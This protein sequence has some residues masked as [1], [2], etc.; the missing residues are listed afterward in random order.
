MQPTRIFIGIATLVMLACASAFTQNHFELIDSLQGDFSRTV[1]IMENAYHSGELSQRQYKHFMRWKIANEPYIGSNGRVNKNGRDIYREFQKY[2]RTHKTGLDQQRQANGHWSLV[3]P[4]DFSSTSPYNGRVNCIAVHPTNSN[5]IYVGTPVGGIWRSV[6]GGTSWSCLTDGVPFNS[7][8]S[9]QLHPDDPNHI[10]ALT[11]DGESED[12]L[13]MGLIESLDGGLSWQMT[14]LQWGPEDFQVGYDLLIDP[15]HPETMY[16]GTN[17]GLY[18]TNN[19]WTDTTRLHTGSIYDIALK[20]GDPGTLYAAS[21]KHLFRFDSSGGEFIKSSLSDGEGPSS[22]LPNPETVTSQRT[23]LAVSP[24]EPDWIYMLYARNTEG[25]GFIGLYHSEDGGETFVLRSLTPNIVGAGDNNQVTYDLELTAD[26][27]NAKTVYVGGIRLWRSLTKGSSGSWVCLANNTGLPNIHA[28]I[29][30][31]TFDGSTLFIGT[32]GGIV[33]STN[34]GSTYTNISNGLHIMQFY[35]FDVKA[36]IDGDPVTI[37]GGTQDNGTLQWDVGQVQGDRILGGDGFETIYDP[38]NYQTMYGCT[39][40]T[41]FRSTNGGVSWVRYYTTGRF[42][43][44]GRFMDHAS[45]GLRHIV[46]RLA[47]YQS[48]V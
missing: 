43:Q 19:N 33:K 47:G 5:I 11:G 24:A 16:V 28:D 13:S 41:R 22:G 4:D 36:D 38:S 26:P 17:R 25:N 45:D 46:L 20:P 3:S 6:N 32:D 9:I 42:Q 18:A 23:A 10:Y 15:T 39:Q 7:I 2:H 8:S 35:D 29:H 21:T 27:S 1:A 44:L 30:E 48:L 34:G 14:N 40:E 31:I 12:M 37:A